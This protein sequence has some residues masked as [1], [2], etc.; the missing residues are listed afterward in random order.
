MGITEFYKV[1]IQR[2]FVFVVDVGSQ[3]ETMCER[4]EGCPPHPSSS[5]EE[6]AKKDWALVSDDRDRVDQV[7][8]PFNSENWCMKP[9]EMTFSPFLIT[10]SLKSILR[11]PIHTTAID[12][13]EEVIFCFRTSFLHKFVTSLPHLLSR[14]KCLN[15]RSIHLWNQKKEDYSQGR[16][17]S[18]LL[19]IPLS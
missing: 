7:Q 12:G 4:M 9:P 14:N 13:P 10:L 6:L 17:P 8:E 2:Q 3:T 1:S 5:F 19:P 16:N 18:F 15:A 11:F